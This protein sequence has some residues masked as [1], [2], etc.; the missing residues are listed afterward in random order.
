MTAFYIFLAFMIGGLLGAGFM[1]LL[2]A[3]KDD[4]NDDITM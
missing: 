2:Q 3:G 1:A 4:D